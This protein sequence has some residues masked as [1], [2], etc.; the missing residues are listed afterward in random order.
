L[1]RDT[2]PTEVWHFD[3]LVGKVEIDKTVEDSGIEY[4]M[5]S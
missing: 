5:S 4:I 3:S 2:S 1:K